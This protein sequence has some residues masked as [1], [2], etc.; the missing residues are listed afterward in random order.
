MK[1]FKA[2]MKEASEGS[3]KGILGYTEDEVVSKIL[4]VMHA[5]QYLMQK[6]VSL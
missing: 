6:Q 3:M 2:A 4:K 1:T 5:H